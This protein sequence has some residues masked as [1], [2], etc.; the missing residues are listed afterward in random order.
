VFADSQIVVENS[1]KA[2][3]DNSE[4]DENGN[5]V[6]KYDDAMTYVGGIVGYTTLPITGSKA[7]CD[8]AAT[9]N[10]KVGFI[11][12]VERTDTVIAS[13][14]QVGGTLASVVVFPGTPEHE[15]PN[16]GV[17]VPGTPDTYEKVSYPIDA[18]NW[19]KHIYSAEVAEEVATEDGCELIESAPAI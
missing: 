17:I 15:D 11:A 3:A 18:T 7:Y 8:I 14:C 2:Y 1:Q 9:E 16:S 10:A 4:K 12:G 19:F 6:Y 13:N 5:T